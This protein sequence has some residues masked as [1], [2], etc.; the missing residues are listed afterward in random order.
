MNQKAQ[1]SFEFTMSFVIGLLVVLALI[2]MFANKL[3]EVVNDA[4]DEQVTALLD[5]LDD[6]I[7]FAKGT[8]AG[9]K[10]VFEL[11]VAVEGENYSINLTEGTIAI[12]YLSKDFTRGFNFQ[13]NGS[14]CLT[15]LN[16]STR[17][18]VVERGSASVTMHACPDCV[19]D[20]HNCYYYSEEL[21]D[22]GQGDIDITSDF[23]E[24]CQ[25]RYCLC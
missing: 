24:Q 9:Y 16:E 14:L 4:R 2:A 18:F 10:R 15:D 23:T 3:N 13:V 5:I 11:P 12:S 8:Q 19:P 21:D 7:T 22:C 20:F 6:E 17:V 25:E 1:I